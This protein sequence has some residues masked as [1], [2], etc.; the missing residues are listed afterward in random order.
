LVFDLG[1]LPL[2]G[3]GDLSLSLSTQQLIAILATLLLTYINLR[4]LYAGRI[5]Q[6]VFTVTKIGALLALIGL[7]LLFARNPE[8]AN[9][10]FGRRG[11]TAKQFRHSP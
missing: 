3:I 2:P 10:I 8:S 7:G 4:G 5:I 11:S 6:D 9:L 1:V